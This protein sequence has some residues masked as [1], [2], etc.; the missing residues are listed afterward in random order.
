MARLK[1]SKKMKKRARAAG[2]NIYIHI[3]IFW[4]CRP[5]HFFWPY[6]LYVYICGEGVVYMY[7]F[8]VG[9]G[10]CTVFCCVDVELAFHH[11]FVGFCVIRAILSNF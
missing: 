7:L 2:S 4:S 11:I 6:I 5:L 3:Y 10:V 8:A 1:M 9:R